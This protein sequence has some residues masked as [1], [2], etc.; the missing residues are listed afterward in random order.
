MT[1]FWGGVFCWSGEGNKIEN[2]KSH[3]SAVVNIPEEGR[4]SGMKPQNTEI[5]FQIVLQKWAEQAGVQLSANGNSTP[6]AVTRYM[7]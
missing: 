6:D 5:L 4:R 3:R 1:S 7:L 2:D